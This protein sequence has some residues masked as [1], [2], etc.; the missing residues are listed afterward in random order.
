MPIRAEE[1]DRYPA[2]EVALAAKPGSNGQ[3]GIDRG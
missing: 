1:R 2:G 3:Y